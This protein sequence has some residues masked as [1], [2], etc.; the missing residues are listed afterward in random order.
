MTGLERGLSPEEHASGAGLP[1]SSPAV[2]LFGC[3]G[4]GIAVVVTLTSVLDRCP[5]ERVREEEDTH[6]CRPH[7]SVTPVVSWGREREGPR[8]GS[9]RCTQACQRF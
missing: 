4:V 1:A 9:P 2:I 3:H 8:G 5:D 7:F 6:I